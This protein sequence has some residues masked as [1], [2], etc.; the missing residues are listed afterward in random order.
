M[1]DC[2][3]DACANKI[4]INI[5]FH[6][7]AIFK[8]A[9]RNLDWVKFINKNNQ[10]SGQT[11][12]TNQ[13]QDLLAIKNRMF[14]KKQSSIL[15]KPQPNLNATV[16]FYA[17]M[18]LHHH[19]HHPPTLNSMSAISQLLLTRFWPNFKGRILGTSRTDS[20]IFMVTF[21]HATFVLVTLVHIRNISAVTDPILTKL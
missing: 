17:K 20:N 9:L 13:K 21:V 2:N 8:N 14:A 16:G 18:T 15:S 5:C 19:H 1:T 10:N 4:R 6:I 3:A 11:P 7:G 12:L